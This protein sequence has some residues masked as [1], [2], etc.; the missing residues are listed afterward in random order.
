M[1]NVCFIVLHYQSYQATTMCVDSLLKLEGIESCLIIILDNGSPN[2]SYELLKNKYQNELLV[3]LLHNDENLGFSGGNNKLYKEAKNYN[4]QFI[5]ALNN[6]VEIRQKDF[7]RRLFKIYSTHKAYV[8]GP[9]IY[10]P[11]AQEHQSPLYKDLPSKKDVE[12]LIA[13]RKEE[14]AN[15]DQAIDLYR[16][17]EKTWKIRKYLPYWAIELRKLFKHDKIN[18][19]YK[20]KF[21]DN[22]VLQGSC[23]IFSHLFIENE[24]VLFTPDTGFYGEE[25]MLGLRC[26]M[27]GY[28]MLYA[29]NISVIHWHGISSGFKNT[30]SKRDLII[31]NQRLINAYSMYVDLID[32]RC[33][34]ECKI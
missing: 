18:L 19:L 27:L 28:N 16:H 32:K 7:I 11:K 1:I 33:N 31:K 20:Q 15:I 2:D 17:R 26:K 5:V 30:P 29:K 22:P 21:I 14:I 6:D 24:E 8:I 34:Y 4:P 3:K 13:N 25:L 10:C 23:L 12:E 9:D